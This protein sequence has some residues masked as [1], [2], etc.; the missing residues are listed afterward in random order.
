MNDIVSHEGA[1]RPVHEAGD[2]PRNPNAGE[3][4]RYNGQTQGE[5][6]GYNHLPH[7]RVLLVKRVHA[8]DGILHSVEMAPHPSEEWNRSCLIEE[9]MEAF[10]YAPDGAAVRR[11]EVR[12]VEI[13]I[14]ELQRRLSA[15]PEMPR[16]SLLSSNAGTVDAKLTDLVVQGVSVEQL[17]EST[18]TMSQALAVHA[19]SIKAITTSMGKETTL[20]ASFYSERA[21]ASLAEVAE[22]IAYAGHLEKGVATL[23]LYAGKNVHVET[24]V[25][26]DPAPDT[27]DGRI[28]I[29]QRQLYMDEELLIRLEEGGADYSN[30]A[31]F[32]QMMRDDPVLRER[33]IPGIRSIVLMRYRR[34]EKPVRRQ[35]SETEIQALLRSIEEDDANRQSF[36][37]VRNGERIQAVYADHALTGL[38]RLFP[39]AKDISDIYKG[40]FW[41]GIESR[42]ITVADLDYPRHREKFEELALSYRRI[43]VTLWGLDNRL[44][45]FGRFYDRRRHPTMLSMQFQEEH[46]DF[47]A[48]DEAVLSEARPSFSQWLDGRNALLQPGSRVAVVWHKAM[49][50]RSAPGAVKEE[51]DG[52][53]RYRDVFKYMPTDKTGIAVVRKARE[54][55]VVQVQCKYDGY[56]EVK[57]EMR[58]FE[59]D[60]ALTSKSGN[61]FTHLCLDGVTSEEIGW[62]IHSRHE[63]EAYLDYIQLFIAARK[64][65]I[66]E[67]NAQR[68]MIAH[69]VEILVNIGQ[70]SA[71]TRE[72]VDKAVRDWRA[73][74]GGIRLPDMDAP[75]APSAIREISRYA[76]LALRG[77][78]KAESAIAAIRAHAAQHGRR[79]LSIEADTEG[80]YDVAFEHSERE[81]PRYL[82]DKWC[83]MGRADQQGRIAKL[84]HRELPSPRVGRISLH[85]EEPSAAAGRTFA[86]ADYDRTMA[87]EAYMRGDLPSKGAE[88]LADCGSMRAA[89]TVLEISRSRSY[90]HLSVLWKKVFVPLALVS[91]VLPK[92]DRTRGETAPLRIQGIQFSLFDLVASFDEDVREIVL[93]NLKMRASDASYWKDHLTSLEPTRIFGAIDPAVTAFFEKDGTF[94]DAGV[95]SDYGRQC[96]D[97]SIYDDREAIIR[98]IGKNRHYRLFDNRKSDIEVLA[99]HPQADAMMAVVRRLAQRRNG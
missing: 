54:R 53:G 63:R 97:T 49:N 8:P 78:P 35:G 31:E 20:L 12:Q 60:L 45:L 80:R 66:A 24:I 92:T 14:A 96:T 59:V 10:E 48:D 21:H 76:L 99:W 19:E 41:R 61:R 7:G 16:Q 95:T 29:Y 91:E 47:V 51:S 87:I 42:E 56:A 86:G 26:G 28:S 15:P 32:A 79:V 46:L 39:R 44:D 33:I 43:L 73:I 22:T 85:R 50:H 1:R 93:K 67:E 69:I 68:D 37:L 57:R 77:D 52:Q 65:I 98:H 72:A 6:G 83:L 58:N 30:D 40:R 81:R 71:N 13:R 94:D 17:Q 2:G 18:R 34:H 70:D 4:W 36:L 27:V 88:L 64:A 38:P 89:E 90:G 23:G 84:E 5:E 11:E 25:D 74:K 82:K 3:Y 75:Q 9:F 62:Y 55:L